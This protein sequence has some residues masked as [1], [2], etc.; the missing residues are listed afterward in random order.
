MK[1]IGVILARKD[2]KGLKNDCNFAILGS[3][4]VARALQVE[5]LSKDKFKH[6]VKIFS[7]IS[8]EAIENKPLIM[9]G[10]ESLESYSNSFDYIINCT[11]L[12][13]ANINNSPLSPK[14][15]NLFRKDALY[16]DVNYGNET[17]TG[18]VLARKSGIRAEGGIE[19]NKIQAI[20]A[21]LKVNKLDLT[22]ETIEKILQGTEFFSPV[23]N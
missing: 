11:P 13:S 19:M 1:T 2:S 6:D 20:A 9:F 7:R 3:G 4:P 23:R 18:V 14:A 17:P 8:S 5:I 22:Y 16:F 10:Y 12:G 21:F 15:F